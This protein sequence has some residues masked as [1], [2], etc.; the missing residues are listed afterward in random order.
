MGCWMELQAT[1][2]LQQFHGSGPLDERVVSIVLWL[3]FP[4][5]LG[6]ASIQVLLA[7][8]LLVHLNCFV[9]D[10]C[11]FHHSFRAPPRKRHL[12]P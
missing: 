10:Y 7:V 1:S 6:S 11:F 5:L 3:T 4:S 2:K 8:A 9:A 12:D